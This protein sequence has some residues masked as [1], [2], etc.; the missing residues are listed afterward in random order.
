MD[1]NFV[2]IDEAVATAMTLL[3]K[4][5]TLDKALARQW[6]YL[7]LRNI[8]PT[9]H[10]FSTCTL[11]PN[12]NRTMKKPV[13]MWKPIDIAL[14]SSC[15][16]ELRYSYRGLG[17]RIHASKF[18]S[19]G[20][21]APQLH[22]PI[23]L[24]EDNHAFHLGS[25]G[26]DVSYAVLKYWQLPIDIDGLPQIPEG[27]TLAIAFFIRWMWAIAQNE[28]QSDRQLSEANYTKERTK[29]RNEANLPSGIE[30]EQ[31]GKDWTSFLGA[32]QFK[33]Y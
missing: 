16:T 15:G 9:N 1:S 28:N 25:N 20:E 23:D 17:K 24:G 3:P 4:K 27:F 7:G 31:I 22:A 14:Y 19:S 26:S 10:W 18:L 33:Q 30:M 29:A 21:Y 2:H 8:G 5:T 6:A 11:Y 32:P 12:E 13:D